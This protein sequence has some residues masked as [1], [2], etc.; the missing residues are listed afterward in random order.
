MHKVL[1]LGGG[2]V[3][4]S[5]AE[6]LL[7]C[8]EGAYDVTLADRDD[9]N[10]REAETNIARMKTMV[11]HRVEFTNKFKFATAKVDASDRAAVLD[12]LRGK[13]AVVCMLPYDL[14][15][16]IAEDANELGVHYFD[17]TE[18]V[19][20]TDRV[21]AIANSGRAKVALVPQCGLAP[22]YIAIAGYEVARQFS[23]IH[24]LTLRVGALPQYPT[25]AL[26]YNVT[27]STAGVVNE[28]CEPCNVMLDGAMTRLPALEGLENFSFEG[29]EY[30]A[31]Y[32]SGGVG[33]LIDT[34]VGE[35]RTCPESDV[36]YKTIRYPGHRN[37]MKFLLQ[38]LRLGVEHAAPS[39]G[40][41]VFDRR[42]AIDLLD[43]AIARTLQDVVVVFINCIGMKDGRREQVNFKRAVHATNMFGRVW[44]A[45]E[46]TTA[47]GVCAMVDMHR[48]GKIPQKGF[49]RQEECSLEAF[50]DSLFGLAYERPEVLEGAVRGTWKR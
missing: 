43:H 5:V 1:V 4:K 13:D 3:G 49:V 9:A 50:N 28:Y 15:A 18:D 34:L 47:A 31:F 42:L 48:R 39:S 36:A 35:K 17:V 2:K 10:L 33:S 26:H 30:E 22:G 24:E 19:E 21:K 6:L 14:V 25:N 23:E 37:L 16:G 32:T 41:R 12:L 45:I 27:W 20:T 46:L 8:G 40:G 38:D 7:A 29:V 11:Q 44:P